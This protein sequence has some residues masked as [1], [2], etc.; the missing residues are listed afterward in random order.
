MDP[1]GLLGSWS[2]LSNRMVLHPGVGNG[3]GSQRSAGCAAP[4]PPLVLP[5]P[6]QTILVIAGIGVMLLLNYYG[7]WGQKDELDKFGNPIFLTVAWPW[8]IPIGSTVAFVFGYFLSR[9]KEDAEE[10]STA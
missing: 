7:H 4:R 5:A 6:V 1:C 8:Y 2:S 3:S 9:H 10:T